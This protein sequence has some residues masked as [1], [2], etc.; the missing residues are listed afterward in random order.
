MVVLVKPEPGVS[1][2]DRIS[3]EG[4][5][6]LEKQLR[7]GNISA[8]VLKQWIKRYGEDARALIGRYRSLDDL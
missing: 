6:R 1:R 7:R 5:A 8:A 4:M 2:E 3:E